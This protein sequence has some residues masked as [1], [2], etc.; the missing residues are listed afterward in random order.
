M[1]I[2]EK[3]NIHDLRATLTE[4]LEERRSHNPNPVPLV[5]PSLR[6]D[7]VD[8]QSNKKSS[9]GEDGGEHE[10]KKESR[11]KKNV[12]KPGDTIKF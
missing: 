8:K 9:E 2:G 1:P 11:E 3:I 12:I 10:I 4:A 6:A 5:P 7:E